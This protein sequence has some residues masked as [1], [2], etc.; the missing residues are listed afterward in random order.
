MAKI[1][2]LDIPLGLE[3]LYFAI[4]RF[5]NS[6]TQNNV[7]LKSTF[8]S[9]QKKFYLVNR[10]L[11]LLW[12]GLWASLSVDQK[13]AW[14]LYWGALPFSPGIG[15]GY[16]P[17]S[18]FSA[19]VFYNAAL[20]RQNISP[21]SDFPGWT[22]RFEIP[23]DYLFGGATFGYISNQKEAEEFTAQSTFSL[24]KVSFWVYKNNGASTDNLELRIYSG[25]ATPE[26]GTLVSG[27]TAI[28]MTLLPPFFPKGGP[29]TFNLASAI[30]LNSG[31][32]YYFVLK[33]SGALQL[34]NSPGIMYDNSHGSAPFYSY[35]K[36]WSNNG[37]WHS[38]PNT[39]LGII[40]NQTLFV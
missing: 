34:T 6:L 1:L 33:R 16:W 4:V 12:Q 31:T 24:T 26:A 11:F 15:N 7:A 28:S 22:T 40:L 27:P 37:T 3:E 13:Y 36:R 19:F 8:S 35:T 10:S 5:G 20:R 23:F 17:G 25:G 9:R 18:A 38:F 39:G 14:D 30:T 2:G 32:K 21:L 29:L